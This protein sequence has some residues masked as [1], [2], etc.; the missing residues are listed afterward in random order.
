MADRE[1]VY[2]S[3]DGGVFYLTGDRA[4]EQGV[5]ACETTDGF[6][7]APKSVLQTEDAYSYG[8]RPGRTVYDARTFDMVVR[9]RYAKGDSPSLES[10]WWRA[11]ST[12]RDGELAAYN[13]ESDARRLTV[14]LSAQPKYSQTR[15]PGKGTWRE[16]TLPLVAFDPF[17]RGE[18]I[19]EEV[20]VPAGEEVT[21]PVVYEGDVASWP[22]YT[23]TAGTW[24]LPDGEKKVTLENMER[25][26]S[27]FTDPGVE[28]LVDSTGL[29]LYHK[30][31]WQEFRTPMRRGVHQLRFKATTSG[32]V[33]VSVP[34]LFERPWS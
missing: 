7:H 26:F 1:L 28:T 11:W 4:E 6:W 14:R 2:T 27:V 24:E 16:D 12:E 20:E 33:R 17:W 8:A 10:S 31:A 5:L 9:G 30:L 32:R 15:E 13:T 29:P 21:V 34:Q 3:P 19:V 25:P 22:V 23:C 18:S